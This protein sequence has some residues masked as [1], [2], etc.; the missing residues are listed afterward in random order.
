[1]AAVPCGAAAPLFGEM[2]MSSCRI[3]IDTCADLTPELAATLDVDILG[4]PYIL[5]GEEHIDDIWTSITPKDFYDKLRAGAKASTSAVS[6]GTYMEFFEKCAQEGSPTVYLCFTS[7]LSSSYNSACQAA[8]QVRAEHPDFELY[9][10]D[11]SLPSACA[12]LLALE[13]V[14]QRSAG[15]SA[16][17][18]VDWANEAKSYV[19]GYFSLE[20][21]DSLA[22]GGRIPPAAASLS[23]KLDIKPVLSFDLAGSLSL[24]GVNRGRK[25][26]LK[27]L[28]KL[29]T[30][31]YSFD[32]ALPIVIMT[33]DA[34]KDG[35]WIENAIRK[36]QGCENLTILRSS[37]GPTIGSHVG[38][39]M[40]AVG[41]WGVNR[42]EKI[43]LTDRIANRVR[44]E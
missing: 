26:A 4:F 8:D 30:E 44:G 21:L 16:K 19:H 12:V 1:M 7:A 9:V 36:E 17:Q 13:A 35:D 38:P 32:P 10:V 31:N 24:I 40:V 33:A 39:G 42:A 11:N 28:I 18:L 23:S 43:S 27:A 15:L 37:V 2:P 20:S 3:V 34:E 22:A 41:F 6:L 25:K 14:R 5:D 29:F